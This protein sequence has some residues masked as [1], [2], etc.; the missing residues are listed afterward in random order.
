[1]RTTSLLP[2]VGTGQAVARSATS[3]P[4]PNA[5]LALARAH[6]E[7]DLLQAALDATALAADLRRQ[8]AEYLDNELASYGLP[9]PRP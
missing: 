5:W 2:G 8:A 1:M 7:R 6:A 4:E 3:A 9:G